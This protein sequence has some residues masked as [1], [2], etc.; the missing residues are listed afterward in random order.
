MPGFTDLPPE[1]RVLIWKCCLPGPRNVSVGIQRHTRA[2]VIL[3][4]CRESRA[5]AQRIRPLE[6]AFPVP[7]TKGKV[8]SKRVWFNFSEDR[9]CVDNFLLWLVICPEI[10]RPL[11]SL[12]LKFIPPLF[13]WEIL[14][15]VRNWEK[16]ITGLEDVVLVEEDT[17]DTGQT[18]VIGTASSMVDIYRT[19]PQIKPYWTIPMRVHRRHE[20]HPF[21]DPKYAPAADEFHHYVFR[22]AITSQLEVQV[23]SRSRLRQFRKVAGGTENELA[24]GYQGCPEHPWAPDPEIH[25]CLR[26]IP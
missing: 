2:P 25:R 7:D 12:G 14:N 5:E 24:M 11:R 21:D 19:F 18:P 8:H 20:E 13:S 6:L 23:L 26:H 4:I 1:L 22:C 3:Q 16:A 10:S 15:Y 9:L 17:S